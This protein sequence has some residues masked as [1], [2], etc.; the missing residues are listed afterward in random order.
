LVDLAAALL[1]G[2]AEVTDLYAILT[3]NRLAKGALGLP[4]KEVPVIG[5]W[6]S[7][8]GCAAQE[9]K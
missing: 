5:V 9:R 1:V 6:G 8:E 7:E 4:A 3:T 2:T